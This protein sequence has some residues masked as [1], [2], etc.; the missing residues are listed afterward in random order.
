MFN[1]NRQKYIATVSHGEAQILKDP[2]SNVS[3][4]IPKGSTGVFWK[5]VHIDHSKFKSHIPDDE[6]LITPL[7]EIHHHDAFDEVD[8]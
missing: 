2:K 8:L 7:V 4:H 1:K 3:L 5:C 6:C